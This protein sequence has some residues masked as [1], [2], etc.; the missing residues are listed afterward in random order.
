MRYSLLLVLAIL[1]ISSLTVKAQYD[2]D[3]V[4][5][6]L[7][8]RLIRYTIWPENHNN[9]IRKVGIYGKAS[10]TDKFVKILDDPKLKSMYQTFYI[11]KAEDALRADVVII[12]KTDK[13]LVMNIM[14]I[15]KNKPI[16]MIADKEICCSEDLHYSIYLRATPNE[17]NIEQVHFEINTTSLS[18]SGLKP[19]IR[20][21]KLGKII[22]K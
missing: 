10:Y 13:D 9:T 17:I 18:N 11:T 7:L 21:L 3:I 4:K 8:E 22:K 16:L 15:T 2:E 5:S 1:L 20:L 6:A 14:E 19:D 12:N